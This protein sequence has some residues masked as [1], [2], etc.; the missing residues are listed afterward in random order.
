ME[1]LLRGQ[2]PI[3][4]LEWYFAK[5]KIFEKPSFLTNDSWNI[6]Q[7]YFLWKQCLEM[8]SSYFLEFNRLPFF[9]KPT[10][11][12]IRFDSTEYLRFYS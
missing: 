7:K 8:I 4:G 5:Y 6:I 10:I 3:Y 9:L 2:L 12:H 11:G 1:M